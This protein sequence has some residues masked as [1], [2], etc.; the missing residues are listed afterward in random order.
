MTDPHDRGDFPDRPDHPD[1]TWLSEHVIAMDA[2]SERPDFS[3]PAALAAI[4][5]D[6]ESL[7]YL[8]MNRAKMAATG[9]VFHRTNTGIPL[10]DRI[11]LAI[12]GTYLDAFYL[13]AQYGR[14][15][16]EEGR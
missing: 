14:H 16:A 15:L 4:P 2:A 9:Q 6:P 12:A 3:V 5:I 1:F 13:G 10:T 11:R 8:A 7:T